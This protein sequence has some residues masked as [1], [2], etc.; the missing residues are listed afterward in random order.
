VAGRSS[1]AR[2]QIP[3]TLAIASPSIGTCGGVPALIRRGQM[4]DEMRYVVMLSL[5]AL[6]AGCVHADWHHEDPHHAS[7]GSL[8]LP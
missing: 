5:L 7:S 4:E 2:W 1:A 6:L 3:R 8:T